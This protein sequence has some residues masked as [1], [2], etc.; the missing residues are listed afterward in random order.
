MK[1]LKKSLFFFSL[2]VLLV[3]GSPGCS[4]TLPVE[5]VTPT[6]TSTVQEETPTPDATATSGPLTPIVIPT[7]TGTPLASLPDL[8]PVVD[9]IAPA[10][11]LITTEAIAYD[12]F[13][14]PIPEKG[15]GTGVIFD[16][17]GYI[18]TNSHVVTGTDTAVA[19]AIKVSL[20]DGRTF[21]VDTKNNVW[22]DPLTDLAV[23][24][25]EGD[26]LPSASFADPSSVRPFQ[27]I[28]AI[29]YPFN[30]E[31]EPTVT[32]GIISATGRSIEEPNG[33]VLY[34]LIQTDA[35]INPGNSGGPL[36]N[37]AGYIIGINTALISGSQNIGF[38]IN[39][40]TVLPIVRDL[41]AQGYVTR[42]WLGIYME[43]VNAAVAQSR[44]LT[45]QK[46][47][48]ITRVVSNSPAE[49]MDL[50]EGDVIIKID[51]TDVSTMEELRRVVQSYGIGDT[52]NITY[53]R[54]DQTVIIPVRLGQT[55]VS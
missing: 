41:V 22:I 23:I 49:Q 21:D 25:I 10:V 15:A 16:S 4:I 47:V 2:A 48:F 42:P 13:Q 19:D 26:N 31:G 7:Y 5:T 43:T 8:T 6:V 51:E 32:T 30:L 50:R 46:G 35:A 18:V 40:S 27:W 52:I 53:V 34:D 55:P 39:V 17:Q 14:Q 9:K 54:G 36:V 44:N 29:G 1:R 38:S 20:L 28:L 11:V 37:L 24:K 45:T 33:V 3:T 12:F